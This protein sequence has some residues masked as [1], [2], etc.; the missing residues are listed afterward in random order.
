MC[1][2]VSPPSGGILETPGGLS[3]HLEAA[4]FKDLCHSH[5]PR[6]GLAPAW[7]PNDLG[8]VLGFCPPPCRLPWE[9]LPCSIRGGV[10]PG[11]Q[12]LAPVHLL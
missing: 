6:M 8:E 1:A 11:K 3:L 12:T 2:G 5:H 10:L 4:L 9:G 7:C